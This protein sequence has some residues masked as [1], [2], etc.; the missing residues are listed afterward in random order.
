M[1]EIKMGFIGLGYR[2]KGLIELAI[3]PQFKDVIYVCDEYEDRTKEGFCRNNYYIN[4][5]KGGYFVPNLTPAY[6]IFNK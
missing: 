1:K 3:L 6:N 2:G 4:W 5:G